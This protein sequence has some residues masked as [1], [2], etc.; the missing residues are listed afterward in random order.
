MKLLIISIMFLAAMVVS[1]QKGTEQQKEVTTPTTFEQKFSYGIGLQLGEN[2]RNDTLNPDVDYFAAGLKAG[3]KGDSSKYFMKQNEIMQV[4]GELNQKI[5]AK[6]EAQTKVQTEKLKV[7]GDKYAKEATAF[8][9][10]NKKRKGVTTTPTGLQY[11]IIRQGS[12]NPPMPENFAKIHFKA[13]YI[14]GEE[15]ENSYTREP[16]TLPLSNALPGWREALLMMRPGSIYR[17]Y[18]TAELG[19]GDTGMPPKIPP[20]CP[21]IY[22]LE[23]LSVEKEPPQRQG[24][25]P[26]MPPGQ[27]APPP[28]NPN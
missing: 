23:L 7:L 27:P 20:K 4:L 24:M 28:P 17:I 26:N 18:L 9:E 16:I 5:S 12:G 8:F 10:N 19:F 2:L 25:R 11:E 15:F 22:E 21:T 13:Y 3:L 1:C 14:D 6:R